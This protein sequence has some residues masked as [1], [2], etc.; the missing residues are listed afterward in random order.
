MLFYLQTILITVI[1]CTQSDETRYTT[2]KREIE[3][4]KFLSFSSNLPLVILDTQ[5]KGIPGANKLKARMQI[6]PT[7]ENGISSLKAAMTGSSPM[8][9]DGWIGV[10]SR[11]LLGL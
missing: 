6:I 7:N 3:Q 8:I 2:R 5:G 9:Y 11:S 1:G 4:S 10:E